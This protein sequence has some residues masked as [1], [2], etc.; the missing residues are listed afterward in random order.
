MGEIIGGIIVM[1]VFIFFV[2]K[3]SKGNT[4]KPD[5]MQRIYEEQYWAE[6]EAHT[7]EIVDS[8]DDDR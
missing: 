3:K 6:K 2:M 7:P 8:D 4:R 1:A 5:D